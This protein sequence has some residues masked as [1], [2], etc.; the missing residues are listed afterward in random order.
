MVEIEAEV[1]VGE[2]EEVVE[3]PELAISDAELVSIC[4]SMAENSTITDDGEIEIPIDYYY[5]RR[6]ALVN[7][8]DPRASDYIS[9]DI[10]NAVEASVAEIMPAFAGETIAEFT[11]LNDA[12]EDQAR[13]ESDIINYLLMEEYNGTEILVTGLKDC[14]LHR[15]GYAKVYWDRHYEVGYAN[16]EQVPQEQ[17]QQLLQPQSE[18]EQVE[19]VEHEEV[20]MP[21]QVQAQ[22]DMAMQQYQQALGQHEQMT[23]QYDQALFQHQV[24]ARQT[25]R[26][27]PLPQQPPQ[28]PQEPQR[29][30]FFDLRVKRTRIESAPV[31][32][33]V[34]P[35]C[36]VI[37]DTLQT[38][39]LEK[40]VLSGHKHLVSRSDLIAMGFDKTVVDGLSESTDDVGYIRGRDRD[41]TNT[42]YLHDSIADVE[43]Y[44]LYV[45]L[46]RDGDGIAELLRVII[47]GTELMDVVEWDETDMVAGATCIMPH[48]HQGVSLF[49]VLRSIQDAKTDLR[50][51]TINGARLSANQ[52]LEVTPDA[53]YDDVVESLSGGV[54]RSTKIG[55]VAALPNPEIP[56][57][58]FNTQEML[59]RDRRESGG[60]AIDNAAQTVQ[61]GGD[62]AHGIER[63][64]TSMELRQAMS[65]RT[66]GD[67]FVRGIFLRL[68]S[69]LRKYHQG[70][71]SAKINGKWTSTTPADWPQRSKVSITIGN[72]QG[73]R[74]RQ[75]SALTGITMDQ[76]EMLEKQMPLV[77]PQKLYDASIDRAMY[78][79]VS[80]PEQYYVDPQSEEGRQLSQ[81]Q[82]QQQQQVKQEAD[83][84]K[85]FQQQ[86]AQAQAQAQDKVAQAE[87]AK[88]QVQ[89]QNNALKHEIDRLKQELDVAQS[90]ANL[91]LDKEKLD[92]DTAMR[93]LQL[94][95]E[96]Q[97]QL[98]AQY[99]Q[100][101]R[102]TG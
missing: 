29:P 53:D 99:Q 30:Q 32:E 68:H 33:S 85:Q 62:S 27:G 31:I 34:P 76:K 78:L 82:Q 39:G 102:S 4:L 46:D 2:S 66:F 49:D 35:E 42:G 41:S 7:C 74:Q 98:D 6:P 8:P 65:A 57:S 10:H 26:I 61:I 51:S 60:G 15:N 87:M 40:A 19:V 22:Y 88:A 14:M 89:Q 23:A 72:S 16:Y 75:A 3:P 37:D 5:G 94:E 80:N 64:M 21:P 11:A 17:I 77:T 54:V 81:Q 44:E 55:S 59:D 43:V 93:L 52:R 63:I 70:E 101:M 38:V 96:N 90:G 24:V 12:D 100:N 71:I 45:N 50:R 79:G 69:L 73:E 48:Q 1:I 91:A 67:T 9:R 28:P 84:D 95:E 97:R 36:A 18:G 56:P 13:V 58:V 86:I 25:G 47:A 20:A 92:R 83:Q